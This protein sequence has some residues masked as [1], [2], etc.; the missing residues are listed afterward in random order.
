M[1]NLDGK[2]RQTELMFNQNGVIRGDFVVNIH[3]TA[4]KDD[5]LGNTGKPKD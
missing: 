2:L 4:S 5:R 1:R 3:P